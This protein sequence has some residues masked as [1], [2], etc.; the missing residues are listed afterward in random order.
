[1]AKYNRSS[2]DQ[3]PHLIETLKRKRVLLQ[4]TC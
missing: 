2:D 3:T 1:M 4:L